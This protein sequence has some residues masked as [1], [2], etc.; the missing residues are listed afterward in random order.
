MIGKGVT[1]CATCDAPLYKGKNVTVV[2]GGNCAMD[3]AI[4]LSKIAKTVI[5]VNK[6]PE[7]RGE[8]VLMDKIKAVSNITTMFNATSKAVLDKEKKG[9]VSHLV[10]ADV[11]SKKETEI[12]TDGIFVEIGF[13]VNADWIKGLVDIDER[14]QIK[15]TPNCETNVPGIFAAG[16]VTTVEYKQVVISAGEGA[17][18]ALQAH[19]YVMQ[20]SGKRTAFIDWGKKK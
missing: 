17:K 6:N 16:D 14:K 1:Y 7:F 19:A 12:P 2:G 3:A 18:A 8:S 10:V 13:T 4:L 5:V 11:Q 9:R 15:I 20:K